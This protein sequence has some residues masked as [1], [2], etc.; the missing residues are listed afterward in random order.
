[1]PLPPAALAA[2]RA[3]NE[4]RIENQVGD[5]FKV[6]NFRLRLRSEVPLTSKTNAET[7]TSGSWE[8]AEGRVFRLREPL[9]GIGV[10]I[11]M[12]GAPGK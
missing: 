8:Y 10:H 5:A 1:M 9:T 4:I 11:P 6:R 3:E 7:Y 12:E 2:L